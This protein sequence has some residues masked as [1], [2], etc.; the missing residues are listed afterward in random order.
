MTQFIWQNLGNPKYKDTLDYIISMNC[1]YYFE[2]IPLEK[3][4][5]P[6]PEMEIL[7]DA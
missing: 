4:G 2:Y 7:P 6:V 1:F 3:L 5:L